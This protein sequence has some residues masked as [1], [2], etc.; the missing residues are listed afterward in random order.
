M[1]TIRSA[2][3]AAVDR[4]PAM[5][6]EKSLLNRYRQDVASRFAEFRDFPDAKCCNLAQSSPVKQGVHR[7]SSGAEMRA[8]WQFNCCFAAISAGAAAQAQQ[9]ST[10]HKSGCRIRRRSRRFSNKNSL[11]VRE[12]SLS[13]IDD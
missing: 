2:Q 12:V 5:G 13:R 7:G 9:L 3:P 6:A 8:I 4:P 11:A 1:T 10:S